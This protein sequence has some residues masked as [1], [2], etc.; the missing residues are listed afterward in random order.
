M[1]NTPLIDP[2]IFIIYKGDLPGNLTN[3]FKMIA[4]DTKILALI[5][6]TILIKTLKKYK[7]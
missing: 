4:D 3:N 2:I 1:L 5:C 6:K 7:I